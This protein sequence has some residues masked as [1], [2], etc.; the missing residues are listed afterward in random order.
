MEVTLVY[1]EFE[2][3]KYYCKNN[4]INIVDSKYSE[5]I[6][7]KIEAQEVQK[8]RLM[9]DFYTKSINLIDIK[10]LSKKYITKSIEK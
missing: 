5:N 4:D 6:V 3:F 1:S 7:C 9:K 8:Q 10:E 2:N